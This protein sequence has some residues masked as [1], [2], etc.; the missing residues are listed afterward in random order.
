MSEKSNFT[1]S[2][3]CQNKT[4]VAGVNKEKQDEQE[5]NKTKPDVGGYSCSRNVFLFLR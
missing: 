3:F 2:N 5:T 4:H 1:N